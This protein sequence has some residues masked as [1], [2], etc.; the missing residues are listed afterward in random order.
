M[1]GKPVGR[2]ADPQVDRLDAQL[3]Q[4][5]DPGFGRG[6]ADDGILDDDD[7]LALEQFLDGVEFDRTPKSRM[8]WVGWMKVRPT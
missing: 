7:V 8:L 6:A 3:P 1:A 5:L 4:G 2:S